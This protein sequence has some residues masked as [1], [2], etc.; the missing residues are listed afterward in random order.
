MPSS[1]LK[2]KIF[3][4]L[5][6]PISQHTHKLAFKSRV[7]K[8]IAQNRTQVGKG[9]RVE[10]D[11]LI[12]LNYSTVYATRLQQTIQQIFLQQKSHPLCWVVSDG[13]YN[14][15]TTT[16]KQQQHQPRV[17]QNKIKIKAKFNL[18]KIDYR[19]IMRSLRENRTRAGVAAF[20]LYTSQQ[21]SS[22]LIPIQPTLIHLCMA[23][24]H[25][26]TFSLS[27]SVRFFLDS[28]SHFTCCCL[29]NVLGSAACNCARCA[30]VFFGFGMI[31]CLGGVEV[32]LGTLTRPW[33]GMGCSSKF[34]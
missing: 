19:P 17:S 20:L 29:C 16:P 10:H 6:L 4:G 24:R 21:P 32:G 9:I 28:D 33:G 34:I 2:L 3:C 12:I 15:I 5:K 27:L 22:Q 1:Y 7:P 11:P 26:F 13:T 31:I 30:K 8:R 14:P 18:S 23:I 25:N